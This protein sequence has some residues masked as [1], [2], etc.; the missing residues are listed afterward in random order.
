[1]V[2]TDQSD[3]VSSRAR[4]LALGAASGS[5][6][7]IGTLDPSSAAAWPL[8]FSSMNWAACWRRKSDGMGARAPQLALEH[9]AHALTWCWGVRGQSTHIERSD[10]AMKALE[11]EL[12]SRLDVS[13]VFDRSMHLAVNE[14]LPAFRLAA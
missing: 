5:I 1:M 11:Y 7:R 2:P 8:K 14:N 13:V 10:G 4:D 12:A 9:A 3:H 6:A